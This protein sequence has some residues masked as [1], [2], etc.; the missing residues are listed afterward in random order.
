ML[1]PD[2]RKSQLSIDELQSL[3]Q[4]LPETFD[5]VKRDDT[6]DEQRESAKEQEMTSNERL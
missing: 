3:I 2:N 6:D 4:Q 5:E 1:A